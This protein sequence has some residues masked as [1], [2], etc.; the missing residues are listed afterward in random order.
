MILDVL[1]ANTY[2]IRPL[3]PIRAHLT[4]MHKQCLASLLF[5]LPIRPAHHDTLLVSV[6]AVT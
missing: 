2:K 3:S 6:F 4:S 1:V 5:R